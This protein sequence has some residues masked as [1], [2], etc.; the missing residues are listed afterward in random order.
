MESKPYWQSK[1]VHSAI[2]IIVIAILNIL[3]IG[4][5]TP[6]KTYDTML[7]LEHRER[8]QIKNLLL[9]GGGGGAIYGRAK[10]DKRLGKKGGK[11]E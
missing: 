10:A 4:D 11:K 7:D 6:G 1:T 2:I 3:G 9:I 5:A 8:E